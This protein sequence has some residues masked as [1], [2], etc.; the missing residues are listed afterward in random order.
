MRSSNFFS[1]QV[2]D[3][4]EKIVVQVFSLV[5]SVASKIQHFEFPNFN[6]A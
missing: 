5:V 4:L 1:T 2:E 6:L 3:D